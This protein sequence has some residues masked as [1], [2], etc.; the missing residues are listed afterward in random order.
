MAEAP[1]NRQLDRWGASLNDAVTTGVTHSR[2]VP[3]TPAE[4]CNNLGQVYGGPVV[5]IVDANT[6]S[7]GDLFAAGFV[8]NNVG[9][10]ICTDSAT[11]GGG[12]NV[13]LPR[14]VARSLAGTGYELADIGDVS[15]T[16]SARRAERTGEAGIDIEDTGVTGSFHHD[17]THRDLTQNNRDLLAYACGLLASETVTSLSA[18]VEDGAIRVVGQGLDR[19]Q[20]DVDG[21]PVETQALIDGAATLGLIENWDQHLVEIVG[22]QGTTVRQRRRLPAM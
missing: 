18:T 6:Y 21:I 10:L 7:A 8:D 5:A 3:L 17:V 16:I 11:G 15:F 4:R 2:A 14:D 13:W 20:L 22:S 9:K 19:V 1:Q 12:A